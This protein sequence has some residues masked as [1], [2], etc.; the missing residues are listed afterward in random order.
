[1]ILNFLSCRRFKPTATEE[2]NKLKLT[3][4]PFKPT[5][6]EKINNV[7]SLF[8]SGLLLVL[9]AFICISAHCQQTED[10]NILNK[11]IKWH[12]S[13]SMLI[14]HINEQAFSHFDLRKQEILELKTS[15]DWT[16]RQEKVKETF[17][18]I[19][20]PFP[21]KTPLNP[22]ITGV[23]KKDG[24]RV[25]K[26]IY[27]SMPD[28]HV[29]AC[30]FIPD[31]IRGKRPAVIHVSGHTALSFREPVYQTFIHNLVK[32]GFIV[33]AIEP[34]G[35]GERDQ[36]FDQ[37]TNKSAIGQGVLT[38]TYV[39]DQCFISGS[40]LARYFAW[41]VIRGIDYLVTRKEVDSENIGI[42]G[43][44]GG[45]TQ[46]AYAAAFDERIKAAAPE[47]FIT[48]QRRLLELPGLQDSESNLY[49][50]AMNRIE[51]A[52]FIE[53]RA[54]K[55]MMIVTT[56][57]D[58]F[59][60]QGA[61]ETYHEALKAYEAFGKPENLI[62]AEDDHIHGSTK[63]NRESVYGFFQRF[64]NLPGDQD[65]EEVKILSPEELQV[66]PTGQVLTS[67][68]E[69]TVFTINRSET[70]KLLDNIE[71]SRR[72]IEIH[73]NNVI[74]K[75]RKISGYIEPSTQG[76]T[77]FC[78][79]YNRT[80][81]NIEMYVL[82]G[83]GRCF[84][85]LLLIV[86]KRLQKSGSIIYLH[87]G[88]KTAALDSGT[89]IE[90]LV[91]KGFIVAVPDLSGTGETKNTAGRSPDVPYSHPVEYGIML[92]GR[93]L[94]GVRAGDVIRTAEFLKKLYPANS[95]EIHTIATAEMGP[96]LLH[97]ASFSDHIRN[98]ILLRSPISY[99][100][101][102][103]N[104]YYKVHFSCTVPG[105]LQAYDLPDLI[106]CIAPRKIAIVEPKDHM[107]ETASEEIVRQ[108]L[109]FPLSVYALRKAPDNIKIIFSCENM[110]SL[111][112]WCFK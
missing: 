15:D 40:S 97:A 98:I 23:L 83:E 22:K 77:V 73:L 13:G 26:I 109:A 96:V 44:S 94:V 9:L 92:S 91:M 29:T 84:I 60:I 81:Y 14:R 6:T 24:Y 65:E 53:V 102:V 25:E 112:E 107:L 72:D 28:F 101:V 105:A 106:A 10:F 19:V 88:G 4:L 5:A 42:A 32:K 69:E 7:S 8:I 89:E 1:M 67:F 80:G 50:A 20:G 43:R 35:Q 58:Y 55:P 74:P 85:P 93:S 56:T 76:E 46:S 39:G 99:Q 110:D 48:S 64:L 2:G 61:R 57:R 16:R 104:Q 17:N 11:W 52:D 41:D 12:H 100:S 27:E 38:H 45:G 90:Q 37:A 75:A 30:M 103:M 33:F 59:S 36:Y 21:E 111:A 47:A 82:Q 68:S 3:Q 87:P 62:L 66:T 79:R 18:R 78:G 70:K 63:K 49:Q 34:I 51:H 108:E 71:N 95:R 54:P 31:G 86:P